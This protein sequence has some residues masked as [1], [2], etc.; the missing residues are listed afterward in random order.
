VY[1]CQFIRASNP[2]VAT[3]IVHIFSILVRRE[4]HPTLQRG[5]EPA[6]PSRLSERPKDTG[7]LSR[8][9]EGN[10]QWGSSHGSELRNRTR[11][12]PKRKDHGRSDRASDDYYE[13]QSRKRMRVSS[14]MDGD[15]QWSRRSRHSPRSR[16][17]EDSSEDERNFKRRWGSRSSATVDSRH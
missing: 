17:R 12:S 6:A 13:D 8:S 5:T 14:P 16:T 3:L 2:F 11:S 9:S 7:I 10:R 15:K 4:A 1:N